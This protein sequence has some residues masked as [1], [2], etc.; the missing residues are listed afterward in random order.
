MNRGA[1]WT[2]VLGVTQSLSPMTE[3]TEHT[4]PFRRTDGTH[5]LYPFTH[6]W[7]FGCSHFLAVTDNGAVHV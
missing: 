3:G 5:L 1:W 2:T 7:V 4:A 6:R